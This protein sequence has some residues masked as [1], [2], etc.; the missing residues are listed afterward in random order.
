[1][2][3]D[4]ETR[5]AHRLI[6]VLPTSLERLAIKNV[7]YRNHAGLFQDLAIY[8]AVRLP[9]LKEM[10][11]RARDSDFEKEEEQKGWQILCEQADISIRF[12]QMLPET[13]DYGTRFFFG[14]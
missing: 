3:E 13:G 11:I 12:V 10:V 7:S 4:C 9:N 14:M 5:E 6:D 8:E 2:F 1:M